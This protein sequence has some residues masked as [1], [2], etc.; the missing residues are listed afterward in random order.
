LSLDI[1][2]ALAHLTGRTL[3]YFDDRKIWVGSS[4]WL[5]N[6]NRPFSRSSVHD[7]YDLPVDHVDETDFYDVRDGL[8]QY[9]VDMD[10]ISRSVF[11]Y[12]EDVDIH[13]QKFID[14]QNRRKRAFTISRSANEA[15]I[16]CINGKTMGLYSYC[17]FLEDGL[18]SSVVDCM[19][20]ITAKRPYQLF[21]QDLANHLGS[22]NAIHIRLG[23]FVTWSSAPRT[24]R[25][26]PHEVL[27]N[28]REILP[29]N[30]PLIIC[31]DD[32][33]NKPFFDPIMAVYK[34]AIMID[35][36]ILGDPKWREYFYS[37]PNPDEVALALV[38]QL[39][40]ASANRFVGTLCSTFT[41]L[42][43]R[44]RGYRLGKEDFYFAY[45]QYDRGPPFRN[46]SYPETAGGTYTWNRIP[47]PVAP[48][49]FAWLREW[50][51]AFS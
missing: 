27:N 29:A 11:Y 26:T 8:N 22:F 24:G 37:L 14:F 38:S 33:G 6:D 51:E 4:P 3:V 7:L 45:N 19:K 43:H 36:F 1:G 17:L 31:T 40:A 9:V 46:G 15:D 2:V 28:I 47:Y 35:Q 18:R 49:V 32:S 12:P 25:V 34:E 50:P 20:S 39:V 30:E 48:K 16:L 23:D 5:T 13:G 10:A 21:A 41:A 42:I 44:A